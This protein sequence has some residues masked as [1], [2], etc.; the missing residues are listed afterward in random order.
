MTMTEDKI[1][2]IIMTHECQW[3]IKGR[4][5]ELEILGDETKNLYCPL[6]SFL[7]S[8]FFS[9]FWSIVNSLCSLFSAQQIYFNN[10][11]SVSIISN[12]VVLHLHCHHPCYR[13]KLSRF[14]SW[15]LS[16]SGCPQGFWYHQGTK[17]PF[18]CDT[19]LQFH[20]FYCYRS[21]Q[22]ILMIVVHCSLFWP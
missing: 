20:F 2:I 10:N 22:L 18:P 11:G 5:R 9:L 8:P 15:R 14:P 6:Y 7:C 16:K 21:K 19:L 13:I 17:N 1:V 12:N 4:E 3:R